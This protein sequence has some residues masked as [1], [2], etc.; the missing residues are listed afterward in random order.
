MENY[1]FS[2]DLNEAL[3][4][5]SENIRANLVQQARN[6]Q[7]E[8]ESYELKIKTG[9]FTTQLRAEQ[10]QNRLQQKYAELQAL[11]ERQSME[12]NEENQRINVQLRDTIMTHLKEYNNTKGFQIIY[13]NSSE[14]II[15]PILWAEDMY[16][17]TSE[18]TDYLNKKSTSQG[19]N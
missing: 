18:F 11:E 1:F 16:N 9:A 15:S 17:I 13:S 4:R 6:F 12:L 2:V 7:A 10:E 3:T 8:V 14:S 5:K 19:S